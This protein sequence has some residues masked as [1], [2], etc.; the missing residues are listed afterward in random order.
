[1]GGIIMEIGDKI[2]IW[3]D[4]ENGMRMGTPGRILNIESDTDTVIVEYMV[5][6]EII[7]KAFSAGQARTQISK[8]D[9]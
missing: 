9:D 8:F 1:M 2:C 6:G 4:C 3:F 7:T 5:L